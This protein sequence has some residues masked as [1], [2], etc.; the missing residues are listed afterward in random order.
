MIARSERKKT[1]TEEEQEEVDGEGKSQGSHLEC[2]EITCKD[3][4]KTN[5]HFNNIINMFEQLE[6]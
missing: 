4:L 3:A 1:H 6:R 5:K 2:E